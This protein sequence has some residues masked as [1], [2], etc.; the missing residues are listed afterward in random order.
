MS[1]IINHYKIEECKGDE[2]Q[3]DFSTDNFD[4]ILTLKFYNPQK[5]FKPKKLF[6]I[7]YKEK[8]FYDGYYYISSGLNIDLGCFI[9]FLAWCK[10]NKY[11][12]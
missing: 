2:Y 8:L 3:F 7:W 11:Y 4:H 10:V 5:R 1:L 6:E 12:E 9:L